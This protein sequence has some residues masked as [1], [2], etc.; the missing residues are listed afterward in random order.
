MRDLS[1]EIAAGDFVGICGPSGG[2][3]T[4]LL[5]LLLG[6]ETPRAGRVLIDGL[7]VTELDR[8]SLASKVG[9]VLQNAQLCARIPRA[10]YSRRQRDQS[11]GS[12]RTG[13]SAWA[14]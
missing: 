2:G 7:D 10:K 1:L 14:G 6:L 8:A 11:L 12:D 5:R 3:K 9:V 13:G 4:T